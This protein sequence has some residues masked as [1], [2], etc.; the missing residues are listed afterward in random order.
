MPTEPAG[1]S[2]ASRTRRGWSS[3]ARWLTPLAVGLSIACSASGPPAVAEAEAKGALEAALNAWK[4]GKPCGEIPGVVP[5]TRVVDSAWMSGEQLGAFA[6][7]AGPSGDPAGGPRT[8]RVKLTMAKPAGERE[9]D[10]I[11][12]GA[13]PLIIY[14]DEDFQRT[15]NMDNNPAPKRGKSAR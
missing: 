11:L 7:V 1:K 2:V 8:F 6:I 13:D 14:R 15:L 3:F 5:T 9:V 12:M 4:E 10:Y